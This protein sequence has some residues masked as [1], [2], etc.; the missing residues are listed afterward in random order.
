MATV[1]T[2]LVRIEA[3][4]SDLKRDLRR[5]TKTVDNSADKM[6]RSFNRIGKVA[7]I[8]IAGVAVR[9]ISQAT[10][11][12]INMAS[13]A[14]E[15]QGKSSVVFGKFRDDVVSALDDFGN[16]VGRSTFALE[17]M[18]SSLQDTFVPMGFARGEAAKLSVEMTK[19]AVDVGSFNDANEVDTMRAFQSALVGNHETVRRFGVVITEATLNQELLTMGIEGGARAASNAEKVQARMNLIMKGTTDAQGDAARTST[20]FANELRALKANFSEFITE[21]GMLFLPI[22]TKV[23]KALN[24]ATDAVRG[25]FAALRSDDKPASSIES[26]E[27][28]VE[29]AKQA[30]VDFEKEYKRVVDL[31]ENG[32]DGAATS[33]DGLIERRK[34][35]TEN[36]EKQQKILKKLIETQQAEADTAQAAEIL[37]PDTT[38]FDAEMNK[39][40]K[41]FRDA[42]LLAAGYSQA[43]IDA[44]EAAGTLNQLNISKDG[45][46]IEGTM[47]SEG[48]RQLELLQAATDKIAMIKQQIADKSAVEAEAVKHSAALNQKFAETK[49]MAENLVDPLKGTKD[50]MEALR[51]AFAMGKIDAELFK[52][53]MAI[54]GESL[55]TQTPLMETFNSSVA[56]MAQNFSNSL[57]DMMVSGKMNLDGLKDIFKSFVKTMLAKAIELFFIN[58]MMNAI[59]GGVTGYVPL[60]QM[61]LSG[62]ASGGNVN[63]NQPYLVGERGP[64]LFVPSSAG[65]VMNNANTKSIG[66]GGA[67]VNQTIN[68]NA[69][70]SQT[71]RAEM[72]NLLPSIK[73]DTLNAVIDSKN[74]GGSFS[75]AF[76]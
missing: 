67:V 29:I 2:L 50:Q 40:A 53:A 63:S 44:A 26:V 31:A 64:E 6:K 47:G 45:S 22:A 20:S 37:S 27:E 33:I 9:A 5:A 38:Q 8:A 68:V 39:Q 7:K 18:A 52:E 24:V 15:M 21:L 51:L 69:G 70:V 66:G 11:K 1:D 72:L 34:A 43:L 41:A 35:L 23:I 55:Q 60:P 73:Q 62:R 58:Q 59:F 13:G 42:G 61:N 14:E 28:S 49:E 71:V 76:A 74:R 25:L 57:A 75:K 19:L 65:N 16:E 30:L 10:V 3:D 46:I 4:I 36:L 12:M 54:L 17:G 56:T 32:D 48:F